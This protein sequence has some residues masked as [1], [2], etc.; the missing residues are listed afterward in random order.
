MTMVPQTIRL[1]ELSL[2]VLVG[3]SGAGK[4]TFAGR[5]F[6]ATEVVSSD[7]CRGLV[8]DDENSMDASSDAFDLLRYIVDKR[9]GRG[10]LT[11]IDATNVQLD[12]RKPF[13]ALARQHH[14]LPVAI[15]LDVPAS[16]CAARNQERPDRNFGA[17]VVRRHTQ[18]L[19]RSLRSLKREGFRQIHVLDPQDIE[20]VVFER[21]RMWPDKRDLGGPFDIIGDIHGCLDE[22]L[23]LAERLGW[24][25]RR[26]ASDDGTPRW[27]AMAPPGRTLVFLGDLIDR[28]PASHEVLRLVMDLVDDGVAL[29]VPGNHDIKLA[30]HLGGRQVQVRHGLAETL[31]Q[32]DTE[33]EAFRQR[34]RKFLDGLVSHLV[35]DEGRLVV[36]HA[37][38]RE[39]MHGRASG[40]VRSFALFG[41]TTG[42]T[43][44][45]GLPVRYPW[46]RD[47]RGRAMVVYG[48]TPIP[49]PEWTN[50]TINID[51]GCVFGGR[52]T[53]LRYPERELVSVPATAVHYEPVRPLDAPPGE[54][55]AAG[56]GAEVSA[57]QRHDGLLDASDV[58]GRQVV[59]TRF[60]RSVTIRADR[61]AAAFEV[62]CR[63]AVDP[64]WL[65]YLPPTMSP[66]E[67]AV[68]TA[69]A[70]FL[71]H[72]DAAFAHYRKAGVTSL[73]CQEKHMGSRAILILC[74]DA[75]A[76][77]RRFG[78]T[79]EATPAGVV[80]TRTGRRFFQ[81]PGIETA[82]LDRLR[83]AA[84]R[85]DLWGRLDSDWV[86]LDT[87]LMPWSVKA[88]ALLREQYAAVGSAA[89]AS[90][91]YA[92]AALSD[93]ADRGTDVEALRAAFSGRA[94][95]AA[96]FAAAYRAYCWPVSSVDD[97]AIAPFHVLA[98]EGQV[99][100][101][102]DHD[103]HM[104]TIDALIDGGEEPILRRTE[105]RTVTLGDPT[106]ED[107]ARDWWLQ[108]TEQGGEGMVIKPSRFLTRHRERLVQPA[109]KCRGREYLRIIY[110]PSYTEDANLERL[111]TRNLS[112][113]RAL[114]L[115]ELILG[116][117]GLH[118]FVEGAPL[119]QV[120]ACAHGVLALESEPVDPRL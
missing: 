65:I 63:F 61:T 54:P 14:V 20:S 107:A 58:L 12:A 95:D 22:L 92:G 120:H 49:E 34:V 19:R 82:F 10:R 101:D 1:P 113:K 59:S 23:S 109:V 93:A 110:G 74:R 47:Y 97:L 76:A 66:C 8:S 102:R 41:E 79:A 37:G 46:A 17:H 24:G 70:G 30:R 6:Q 87:E 42:E 39:D 51:T 27:H 81:D 75:D 96:R 55:G 119:H 89:R 116:L 98:S 4:S 104:A 105:R 112:T 15:V 69:G 57:R 88:Q 94:D 33:P 111:R 36:A 108:M 77:R 29:C 21:R 50:G 13:I 90:L 86:M 115:K 32:L 103:W 68:G 11:V 40:Q 44:A 62:M 31:E 7:R 26:E 72:P 118:R 106:T 48:H 85:A 45:Y 64:R 28:G 35:L 78:F 18:Q 5:H 84:T 100:D 71:E 56:D 99:Y 9:L 60:G 114:A 91:A 83:A 25:L 16:V 52:L 53:A 73:V 117:E 38:L 80:Y 43:D 67:T 3:A 2:V